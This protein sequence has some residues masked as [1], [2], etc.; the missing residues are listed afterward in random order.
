M[1]TLASREATRRSRSRPLIA[2]NGSATLRPTELSGSSDSP[3][4]WNTIWTGEA[5]P[6]RS[7]SGCPATST[8]PEV[9]RSRPAMTLARVLFPAPLSPTTANVRRRS[10]L[11]QTSRTAT[12]TPPRRRNSL[13]TPSTSRAGTVAATA[14]LEGGTAPAT[15]PAVPGGGGVARLMPDPRR[16]DDKPQ[17]GRPRRATPGVPR[18]IGRTQ[19]GIAARRHSRRDG[20]RAPVPCPG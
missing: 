7:T 18:R 9:G 5:T 19:A 4:C 6:P 16:Q 11:H 20:L 8:R 15:R 17:A 12:R 3:G 1:P 10:T 14:W 13:R 2:C